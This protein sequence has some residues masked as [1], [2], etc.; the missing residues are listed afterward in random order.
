VP[1]DTRGLRLRSRFKTGDFPLLPE[2]LVFYYSSE[3]D[4][5]V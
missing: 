2:S 3:K 4:I 1:Y 5:G